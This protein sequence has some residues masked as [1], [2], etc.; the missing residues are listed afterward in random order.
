MATESGLDIAPS[1]VARYHAAAEE[2]ADEARR[3]VRA[4]L[5]RGFTTEAKP[6]HSPVTSVDRAVEDR[7]RELI[8]RWFPGH[9]VTGEEA[10]PSHP[11]SAFQWI[12]DPID[13]TEEFVRGIPTYGCMLALHHRGAPVVGVIEHPGLDLRVTA[14]IGR[15]AYRNG[16]RVRLPAEPPAGRREALRLVL[17][18]R[19]N[20][21][22]HVDEGHLFEALTRTYPN[23]RIYRAAYA[24]TVVV[25]GAADVMV[26]V[27]NHIWDVAPSRVLVEEAGGRFELV[28]DVTAPDGDRILSA[29][30][31]QPRLVGEVAALFTAPGPAPR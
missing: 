4:A 5:D 11:D 24:H 16:A 1:A 27:Q 9:G 20:F 28:R 3:I 2:L 18:A 26:D 25:T 14:A 31:G 6:D 29:V 23:H 17:S 13:G 21:V 12:L 7:W 19:V 22:R 30:F 15:G 8:G 10:P